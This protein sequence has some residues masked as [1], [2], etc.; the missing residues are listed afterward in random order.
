MA[1]ELPDLAVR[2][3]QKSAVGMSSLAHVGWITP[4]ASERAQKGAPDRQSIATSPNSHFMSHYFAF[5][6]LVAVLVLIPGPAVILT[7]QKAVTTGF[8]ALCASQLASLPPTWCGRLRQQPA[9]PQ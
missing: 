2:T 7:M 6:A 3:H 4:S 5:V 9:C 1:V 8:A